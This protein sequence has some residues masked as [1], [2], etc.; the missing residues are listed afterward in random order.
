MN[1]TFLQ[2]HFSWSKP[3]LWTRRRPVASWSCSWAAPPNPSSPSSSGFP[4]QVN[5][6]EI[7][8]PVPWL[9]FQRSH[10]CGGR[11]PKLDEQ[12]VTNARLVD[13]GAK[14]TLDLFVFGLFVIIIFVTIILVMIIIITITTILSRYILVFD[15]Y[16]C[17]FHSSRQQFGEMGRP[18]RRT[19][20]RRSW[21]TRWSSSSPLHYAIRVVGAMSLRITE[22][23]LSFSPHP[24]IPDG[25]FNL[26][27]HFICV[28]IFQINK[29]GT[30]WI[31]TWCTCAWTTTPRLSDFRGIFSP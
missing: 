21:P 26:V 29:K 16:C 9:P 13:G 24:N 20:W 8:S 4:L 15:V 30:T 10:C 23:Y 3:G 2:I 28:Q 5:I 22:L 17:R 1:V 14:V 18:W 6:V 27:H 11:M 12:L 7:P 19:W 31:G 25:N